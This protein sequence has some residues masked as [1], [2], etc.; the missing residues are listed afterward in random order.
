MKYYVLIA[1]FIC[2]VLN[3][4]NTFGV[5]FVTP[6]EQDLIIGIT[7]KQILLNKLKKPIKSSKDLRNGQMVESLYYYY[8]IGQ[9]AI[10]S[11]YSSK[12][13]TAFFKND[14]LIGYIF[15]SSFKEES[16]DFDET[17]VEKIVKGKSSQEDVLASFGK[18]SG[19]TLYPVTEEDKTQ[20]GDYNFY[21]V[22]EDISTKGEKLIVFTFGSNN[23]VKNIVF[24]VE[25][26]EQN[27]NKQETKRK[28]DTY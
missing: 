22:F 15:N 3:S 13:F 21:Y 26:M 1:T 6:K 23:I 12:A 25:N 18:P 8:A 7:T 19:K 17:K 16:T 2:I 4:C 20:E 24:S 27:K 11:T 28:G 5:N 10:T 9:G 14:T